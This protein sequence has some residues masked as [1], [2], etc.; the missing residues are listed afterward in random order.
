MRIA[1]TAAGLAIGVLPR[2]APGMIPAGA[3]YF[4]FFSA[5]V[6]L[7]VAYALRRRWVAFALALAFLGSLAYIPLLATL[8]PG[9]GI[10]VPEIFGILF[11]LYFYYAPI[12]TALAGREMFACIASYRSKE[13]A[14]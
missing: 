1:G 5:P 8:A 12:V 9:R 7:T 10:P 13:R 4:W 6:V 3:F 14:G 2:A 11:E